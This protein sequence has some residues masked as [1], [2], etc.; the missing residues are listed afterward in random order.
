M[1]AI[2]A[3]D[4]SCEYSFLSVGSIENAFQSHQTE[5]LLHG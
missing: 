4:L 2:Y 1:V 5:K 3:S